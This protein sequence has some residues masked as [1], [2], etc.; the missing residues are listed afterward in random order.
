MF[1]AFDRITIEVPELE[2][3]RASYH[4][5]LGDLSTDGDLLLGN[6]GIALR[7]APGLEKAH[8]AR[9]GLLDPDL[10]QGASMPIE[11]GPL[12]IPLERSHTRDGIYR[13]QPTPTGIYAVDHVV[14]QTRDADACITL[15]RDQLGLRL[16]LD[17]TVP[18]FGGRML[19]FR[20]GKMTLEVIQ[21][22]ERPPEQDYFW[23]ITYLCS[24]IDVTVEELDRRG[25][26]HSPIRPGRKPGTRVTTVKSHCLDLPTLLI[27]PD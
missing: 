25:V 27:G 4:Q 16:A 3:A 19:F 17:Q 24:D 22:L 7:Q 5:L 15:F 6:V 2:Q 26:F 13:E 8:I 9:L 14:L 1:T 23:G 11:G 18:E 20:H 21:H 10:A 12:A